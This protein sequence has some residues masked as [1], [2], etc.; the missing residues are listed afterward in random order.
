[1]S[2]SNTLEI[3]G[4]KS[5]LKKEIH[6]RL[7]LYQLIQQGISKKALDSVQR[8]TGFSNQELAFAFPISSRTLIRYSKKG[9]LSAPVSGRLVELAE[10]FSRGIEIFGDNDK[11]FLWLRSPSVALGEKPI[12]LIANSIGMDMLKDELGRIEHGIFS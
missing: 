2:V 5:V 3:L 9:M 1:M 10:L 4:G 7:E 8:K 6:S 12:N 11:F